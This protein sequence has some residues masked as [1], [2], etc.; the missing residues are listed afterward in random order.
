MIISPNRTPRLLLGLLVFGLLALVPSIA[1]A[2]VFAG[3]GITFPTTATVGDKG[4]PASIAMT[5]NN[6]PSNAGDTNTVCNGGDPSPPCG[7]PERGITLVPSCKQVAGGLCTAA[8]ADPGVFSVSPTASGRVGTACG[9]MVFSAAVVDSAFGTVSFTPQPVPTHV[10]LPAAGASCV[11][12][13]TFDVVKAPTGDAD[14]VTPGIQTEQ[15]AANTQFSGILNNEARGTSLG[16]TIVRA[17]PSIVTAAPGTAVLGAGTL[18][19]TAT[20]K[21]LVSP[22]PG[23]TIDFRLYGDSDTNCT[24][25][26]IFQ[27]LAVPYP[28]SGGPVTSAGYVPPGLGTYR[29]IAS[30][31]GDANNS[32]VAGT[33]NEA[34]ETTAVTHRLPPPKIGL[35]KVATPLSEIAPGG[36]FTF[37]ATVSN[38]ST[39]TPVTITKLVDNIYGDLATRPGSTCGA[40]IG[41]TLAPGAASAPCSFTGLFNG[42]AGDSQTDQITVT[43]VNAGTTVTAVATATVVLTP[44]GG[45]APIR[46]SGFPPC[47]DTPFRLTITGIHIQSV[48]YY[49]EG[50]RIVTVTKHDSRGR[51]YLTIR[52]AGLSRGKLHHL[53]IVA[54]PVRHSGQPLRSFRRT[55]AVCAG[56]VVPRFTG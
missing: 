30:Y 4:L 37:T 49:L 55:F 45:V 46:V 5:N 24:G 56:F 35:T 14:P 42:V 33:C 39:T 25:A 21:G 3:G 51:F 38:P 28:P 53:L 44:P 13:F 22:Q 7:S 8:G 50:K 43:G 52:P 27:S 47:A 23:A 19:D 34:T 18:T 11:I 6:T 48:T 36:T 2:G 10:T 26:P 54:A 32:P 16:T 1:Q 29:W 9:G 41:V 20:V 17:T 12:D 40:L 15:Q 31:S